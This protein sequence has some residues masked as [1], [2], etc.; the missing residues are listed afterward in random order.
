MK[1]GKLTSAAL[2]LVLAV[3][4]GACGK[5]TSTYSQEMLDE[6]SGIKVTAE[7]GQTTDEALTEGAITVKEGDVIVI[8]PFT[9][10]GSFHLTITSSDG[11][12]IY[13]DD[14]SGKVLYTIGAEPGVY[15]VKTN[16]NDVTGWM[17]VAA[18]ST[19]DL[20]AQDEALQEALEGQDELAE[21]LEKQ[22]AEIGEAPDAE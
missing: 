7:N 15:D 13:D 11:K 19:E 10:K 1:F 5:S 6:A 3:T 12:V 20:M 16:G 18:Q 8:S 21:E 4:L 9:E 22:N 14:A 2:A 17:T